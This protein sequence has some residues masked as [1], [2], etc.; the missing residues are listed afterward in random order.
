MLTAFTVPSLPLA[1]LQKGWLGRKDSALGWLLVSSYFRHRPEITSRS[2]LPLH[3]V[4]LFS[5]E[6]SKPVDDNLCAGPEY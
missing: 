4:L 1:K 6:L 5:L 3:C 2:L